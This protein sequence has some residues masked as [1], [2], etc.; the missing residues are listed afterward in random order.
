MSI[1]L[2]TLIA[3]T[4][5]RYK[6]FGK[7]YKCRIIIDHIITWK[8]KPLHGQFIQE[9]DDCICKSFSGHGYIL[10]TL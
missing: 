8:E 4:L 7:E 5:Q 1:I 10:A 3:G 2:K 9:T 6:E